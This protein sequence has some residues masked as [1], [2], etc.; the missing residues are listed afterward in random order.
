M[1]IKLSNED[2][3]VSAKGHVTRAPRS[4]KK[5][6]TNVVNVR[7]AFDRSWTKKQNGQEVIDD[8]G[9]K[10]WER[11]G[12][13]IE[14]AVWGPQADKVRTMNI[15]KGAVVEVTFSLADLLAERYQPENGDAYESIKTSHTTSLRLLENG[16]DDGTNDVGDAQADIPLEEQPVAET[17]I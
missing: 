8:N 15:R 16:K 12:N 2:A 1:Q 9:Q 4:T 11:K 6:G 3:M 14:F 10:V 7:V 17:V 13:I 5:E